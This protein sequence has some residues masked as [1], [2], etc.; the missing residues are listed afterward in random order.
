M[1][2]KSLGFNSSS[3]NVKKRM[4][5]RMM[6]M[7][8]IAVVSEIYRITKDSHSLLTWPSG[9]KQVQPLQSELGWGG[10]RRGVS[11]RWLH[12]L[13]SWPLPLSPCPFN[14]LSSSRVSRRAVTFT[15][16]SQTRLQK[17]N[18]L[19]GPSVHLPVF[20]VTLVACAIVP[21]CSPRNASSR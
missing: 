15:L 17:E 8:A 13:Q 7:A 18:V 10:R 16:V 21:L 14:A 6:L 4:L 19:P 5:L 1:C 12:D 2:T 3:V 9:R 11:R 20:G